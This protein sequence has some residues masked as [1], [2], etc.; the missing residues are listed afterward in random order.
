MTLTNRGTVFGIDG[1]G[2]KLPTEQVPHYYRFMLGEARATIVSDGYLPIGQPSSTFQNVEPGE[3]DRQ[4]EENFLP[5]HNM[6]AEQNVLVLELNGK[7]IVFDTGMGCL[8][9]FE[10]IRFGETPG[11]LMKNLTVA[12]IDPSC[13]DAVVLSH[14]HIDHCGGIISEEGD[15]HFPNAEFFVSRTEFEYWTD[16]DQ[17]N[18]L[19]RDQARRNLLPVHNRI[20]FIEDGEEFLP[21]ITAISTPGHSP[22]HMCYRIVSGGQTLTFLGDLVHHHVLLV[23]T[24]LMEF[25]YDED[26]KQSAQT[27]VKT[28]TELADGRDWCLGFHLPWPGLGHFVMAGEGFRFIPSPMRM[29]PDLKMAE[30]ELFWP[31]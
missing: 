8:K 15:E 3:V 2:F 23:Q 19:Q 4:L 29:L 18:R 25:L 16:I 14:A 10:G 28:L 21:G 11:Q 5:T 12:G 31:G 1:D 17:P 24:P 20:Q 22:G 6:V 26:P 27:R 7:V 9:E 13:V 30:P